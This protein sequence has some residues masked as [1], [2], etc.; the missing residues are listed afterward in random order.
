M[1]GHSKWS[2]I[3]RKKGALDAKRSKI[4]TKIIKEISVAVREGGPDPEGNP[5]L[6]LAI[7]TAKANN[8][9]KEN[10]ER[11]IK[12]SSGTDGAHYQEVT[13]EGYASNGVAVFVE[14]LTDNLNRTVAAVRLAFSK[15]GGALGTNGSLEFIFDRKGVFVLKKG[16]QK[17]DEEEFTLEMIDAGAEDVVFEDEFITVY[18]AFEDFGAMQK[19]V[20]EMGLEGESAEVQ[21][22]PK[23]TVALDLE[24]ARKVLKLIDVLEDDDDVQ[25][26]YHN[27]ELTEEMMAALD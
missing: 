10:M 15:A 14:C 18:T 4:F 6:R 3:K 23:T 7:Q 5:R 9:P 21:R 24:N 25:K 1:S 8:M 2:T 13:Y 19:K 12:K 16:E 27:L 26:V 11:A 22:I 20:E 17:V